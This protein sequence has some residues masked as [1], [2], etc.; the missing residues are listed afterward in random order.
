VATARPDALTD[1]RGTEGNVEFLALLT[2]DAGSV[3]EDRPDDMGALVDTTIAEVR[4][5]ED[6]SAGGPASDAP[7]DRA[8]VPDER[9]SFD[10]G[11]SALAHRGEPR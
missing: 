3:I 9:T 8:G 10:R 1:N 11:P 5:R 6:V 7:T 2:G 4:E